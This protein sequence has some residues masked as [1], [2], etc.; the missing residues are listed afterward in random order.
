MVPSNTRCYIMASFFCCFPISLLPPPK[1]IDLKSLVEKFGPV[2][3]HC[4]HHPSFCEFQ[5]HIKFSFRFKIYPYRPTWIDLL[6]LPLLAFSVAFPEPPSS[7][8]TPRQIWGHSC[9]PVCLHCSHHPSFHELQL[10]TKFGFRFRS[11]HYKDIYT[12]YMHK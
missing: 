1:H 11:Y 7:P 2:C 12:N 3:L 10:C 5:L 9:G 6:R 4:N 8:K